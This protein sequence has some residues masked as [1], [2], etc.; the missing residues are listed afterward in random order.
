MRSVLQFFAGI[1]LI[2][3]TLLSLMG[4]FALVNDPRS[5]MQEDAGILAGLILLVLF[6]GVLWMLVD[7]SEALR[8]APEAKKLEQ[9][10]PA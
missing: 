1:V 8:P 2:V 4:L 7:I 5:M 10:K 9:T 3:G 6:A